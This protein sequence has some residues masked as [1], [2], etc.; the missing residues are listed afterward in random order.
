MV[1]AKHNVF[2]KFFE[3]RDTYRFLIKKKVKRKN[4][5]TR[6]LLSS[7]L[8]KFN[9]YEMIRNDLSYQEKAEVIPIDVVY[10]PICDENFPVPCYFTSEI[11]LAYRSYVGF[12]DKEKEQ[13]KNRTFRQ[14]HYCQNFFAKNKEQIKK[15]LSI[16]TAKEGITY[17]FDNGQTLNYQDNFK[18]LSDLRFTVYFDFEATARGNSVFFFGSSYICNELLSDLFI[19]SVLRVR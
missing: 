17:A 2:L 11:H 10:E 19:S 6:N 18:Y 1:L 9:S 4:E 13:I 16:C 8:E 14:C 7:V 15:L 12:F 5:V 3:R